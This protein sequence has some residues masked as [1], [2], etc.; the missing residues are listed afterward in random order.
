[1]GKPPITAIKAGLLLAVTT[2]QWIYAHGVSSPEEFFYDA[3]TQC[4]ADDFESKQP[5]QKTRDLFF[6]KDTTKTPGCRRT[7]SANQDFRIWDT[8]L[9]ADQIVKKI[10]R[11]EEVG[12]LDGDFKLPETTENSQQKNESELKFA[13]ELVAVSKCLGIDSAMFLGL[14]VEESKLKIAARSG[15]GGAGFGQ[16]T[17]FGLK[18]VAS[19]LGAG[20]SSALPGTI[21]FFTEAI[22]KCLAKELPESS[23]KSFTSFSLDDPDWMEKVKKTLAKNSLLNLILAGVLFKIKLTETFETIYPCEGKSGVKKFSSLPTNLRVA[24]YYGGLRRY[25]AETAL[26]NTYPIY[27]KPDRVKANLDLIFRDPLKNISDPKNKIK[28]AVLGSHDSKWPKYQVSSKES[29]YVSIKQKLSDGTTLVH[30]KEVLLGSVVEMNLNYLYPALASYFAF[31]ARGE[32]KEAPANGYS[33]ESLKIMNLALKEL[34]Q[35]YPDQVVKAK[36]TKT[37]GK[38]KQ[39]PVSKKKPARAEK[40]KSAPEPKKKNR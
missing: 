9:T 33:V 25:N 8:P 35:K 22:F 16:I 21:K 5:K 4:Y 2:T 11:W 40:K 3:S 12:R 23:L 34:R 24:V 7:I 10:N 29:V 15:S 37:T 6:A 13:N 1:M 26:T 38:K 19:Q 39:T 36:K 28:I 32:I 18:E 27:F 31:Q 30:K 20:K 14:I 17:N